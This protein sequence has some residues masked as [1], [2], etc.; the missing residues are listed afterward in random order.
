MKR[1]GLQLAQTWLP[2]VLIVVFL[3]G[4]LNNL[5]G[6]F[7]FDDEG[8]YLYQVWRMAVAGE[9][10]YRDFLT[11]Q[12]PVF[13]FPGMA[14]MKLGAGSLWLMRFY[15]VVLAF[16]SAIV[17][18]FAARKHHGLLM[19][20]LALVLFLVHADV[21]KEMRI[22]RNEPLFVLL[23][24]LGLVLAT[25]PKT[26][27]K[28]RLLA[29]SGVA[30]G[31]AAMVKL[32]GLLPAG[33]VGMWLLWDA[34]S[35]KRPFSQ[36]IRLV[37]AFVLPLALVLLIIAG[38]FA[39]WSPHF[40]DL[41]LGH[42]LAQGS[43]EAFL[44]VL[45]RQ[46]GLLGDYFSFYPILVGLAL[47]SGILGFVQKDVRVRWVW[48]LPTAFALLV[49][50]RE[51]GQRHFM[52]LL[53][54]IILLSSWLLAEL[55][56]GRYQWWGRIIGVIAIIAIIIPFIQQ[57]KYR[58]SWVDTETEPIVTL[59]QENSGPQD[60]ILADD[61][62]L[63][64]YAQRPTTYSGAALSHGAVTSG[65]I[66]GEILIDEIMQTNTR[67]VALDTSLL[68]GNHLVFLRDYP[69]FHRFLENNFTYIGQFD[70]DYQTVEL[71]VRE[72]GQP[73]VDEDIYFIEHPDG[74][75]FGESME[76]LGYTIDNAQLNP[77]DTLTFKLFWTSTAPANNYWS[78]FSHLVDAKTGEVV[79]QHD[80]V[81]YDGVYPPNRWWPAQIID[82]QY[83]IHIPEEVSPG[84]YHINVGMYDWQNGNRLDLITSDN[85]QIPDNVL[86]LTVPITIN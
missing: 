44:T 51:F 3:L 77:G 66:T 22:F 14:V 19:G 18:F 11:P 43:D 20:V 38:G 40:F 75:K 28:P 68:T 15:S 81:P 37:I 61:I 27:P 56:N 16:S 73:F 7:V 9:M 57:N 54:A 71:W 46:I 13:L 12:L 55:L 53:P 60:Y 67:L 70:R 35:H 29:M 32:F 2:V 41:V 58:A 48:Q 85:E 78:V 86:Q 36:L 1:S 26:G 62:G 17:M 34:W 65:Q 45:F 72:S 8:E 69:R 76:L 39:I 25:W 52:Y 59:I 63:A 21:F 4:Y 23:V 47:L 24:T 10:P 6:W 42:H 84:A 33:G 80:K 64:Y 49:L 82:D 79:G 50:S 30:F 83:E 74:T 31:L 5:T